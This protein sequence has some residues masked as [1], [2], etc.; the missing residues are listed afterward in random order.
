MFKAILDGKHPEEK[1]I[2]YEWCDNVRHLT[3]RAK[4]WNIYLFRTEHG[5]R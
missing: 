1:I 2:Y 3:S 4:Y 5:N